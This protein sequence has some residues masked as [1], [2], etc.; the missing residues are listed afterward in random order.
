MIL[1][2][3]TAIEYQLQKIFERI[4]KMP[5][6]LLKLCIIVSALPMEIMFEI[7]YSG[8]MK[9]FCAIAFFIFAL[10]VFGLKDFK[11]ISN[12][13]NDKKVVTFTLL[14]EALS[15]FNYFLCMQKCQHPLLSRIP[16]IP[17]T[18]SVIAIG[19]GCC[20]I[21]F[22]AILF[23]ST[24]IMP[25]I[26]R[27]YE[28]FRK[29]KYVYFSAAVLSALSCI[30][31]FRANIY[32]IDD[33]ERA[34][35]GDSLVGD[36]GRYMSEFLSRF[37][38]MGFY[39]SDV[40]PLPQL[41]AIFIMTFAGITLL[42]AFSN[43]RETKWWAAFALIPMTVN[44]FFLECLSYKYD[45]PYMA[46]S[47]FAAV[48]PITFCRSCNVKYA[49]ISFFA[50][51]I[52]CTTY[53]NSSGIFPM[54]V[55]VMC[56]IMWNSKKD[57]KRIVRFAITSAIGY[58]AGLLVFRMLLMNPGNSENSYINYKISIGNVIPNI[59]RYIKSVINYSS[60]IWLVLIC[61]IVFCFLFAEVYVSK[62]IKVLSLTVGILTVFVA[63][64]VSFGVNIA[65]SEVYIVPRY[66]YGIFILASILCIRFFASERHLLGKIL[67]FLL[68]WSFVVFAFVYGNALSSQKE[69]ADFR[70]KLIVSDLS[71]IGISGYQNDEQ[72]RKLKITGDIGF[73]KPVQ[74]A[75]KEYP[76]LIKLVPE[77]LGNSST[78]WGPYKLCM[79]YGLDFD[80]VLGDDEPY[81]D[82]MIVVKDTYYHCIKSNEQ[83]DVLIFLK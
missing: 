11:I 68:S 38:H 19:L 65:F 42:D 37:I 78:Y 39:L 30:A 79:F 21:S 50:T 69:Y 7:T 73:A 8:Y 74:N 12:K 52:M 31:I 40:S 70:T 1:T 64:A 43:G 51:I 61:G 22:F 72:P 2:N 35:C 10:S 54:T 63:V 56:F 25:V 33:L 46:L 9:I 60:V 36:F 47:V 66:I 27:Y 4:G 14:I 20:T 62:Q 16:F 71:E 49:I 80:M 18:V 13:F 75:L 83:G 6:L 15:F 82:N 23:I 81:G 59:L 67:S 28:I 58:I 34:I 48:A 45:A 53:Q 41:L 55:I 57:F 3:E 44:P 26:K 76:L 77:M 5:T 24:H 32:Y 17:V 29:Y